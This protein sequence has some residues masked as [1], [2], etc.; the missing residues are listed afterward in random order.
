VWEDELP[1][2][3]EAISDRSM[4]TP[5]ASEGRNAQASPDVHTNNYSL[6]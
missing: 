3:P 2:S 6:L 4:V 1:K 5:A